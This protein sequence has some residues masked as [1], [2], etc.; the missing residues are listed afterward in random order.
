VDIKQKLRARYREER[1]LK[2]H[3]ESWVHII[4]SGE[5]RSAKTIATYHSYNNEPQTVD[6]N[7]EMISRGFNLVLPRLLSDSN[8]EWVHWDGSEKSL[9]KSGK[10]MEPVGPVISGEELDVVIVPTL[11]VNQDGHRL[12]QG[13]GSYDRA[14]NGLPAWKIG[15]I[16]YGELTPEPMPVERH[17]VKLSAVATPDLI[18]RFPKSN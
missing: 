17:D 13:G 2:D 18:I 6:L 7:K 1:D 14:L 3:L 8:L 5:F 12:G 4:N 15:L 16:Y 9:R 10:I 11:H